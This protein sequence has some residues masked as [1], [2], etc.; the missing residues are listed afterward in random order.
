MSVAILDPVLA[1]QTN[2]KELSRL[3]KKR[4]GPGNR[5]A[6]Y[7]REDERRVGCSVF[8]PNPRARHGKSVVVL[9][10]RSRRQPRPGV[11]SS[12]RS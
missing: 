3:E 1:A 7:V 6:R 5:L 12:V 2:R 8:T 10:D 9:I 11:E 4:G